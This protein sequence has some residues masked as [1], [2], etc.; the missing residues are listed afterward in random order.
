VVIIARWISLHYQYSNAGLRLLQCLLPAG[1]GAI[2]AFNGSGLQKYAIRQLKAID[3]FA[4]GNEGGQ[5]GTKGMGKEKD[6]GKGKGKGKE[7]E[8]DED[9]DEG[10]DEEEEHGERTKFV[11]TKLNPMWTLAYG[12]L[13]LT[14]ASYQSSISTSLLSL[15]FSR[16]F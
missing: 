11:P 10:E 15:F 14:S 4:M 5:A 12:H 3:R 8:K 6:K 13:M 2:E 1:V 16:R 9:E 7:R